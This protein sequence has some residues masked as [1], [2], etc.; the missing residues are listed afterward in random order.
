MRCKWCLEQWETDSI[1]EEI[2]YT[3]AYELEALKKKYE[4]HPDRH[5]YNDPFQKE[6]E[7]FFFDPIRQKFYNEGCVA[8][9]GSDCRKYHKTAS[10]LIEGLQDILGDDID[11]LQAME[12]DAEW[13]GID[14]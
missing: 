2:S 6:Y 4:G 11:G 10:P 13:M 1:H 7:K 8:I 14:L 12:E 9:G 5:K 3:Y